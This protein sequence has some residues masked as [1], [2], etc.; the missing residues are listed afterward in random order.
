MTEKKGKGV[1]TDIPVMNLS[2]INVFTVDEDKFPD[3]KFHW[4]NA[5]DPGWGVGMSQG[6]M[7]CREKEAKDV[8]VN[9]YSHPTADGKETDPEAYLKR[10]EMV[11]CWM[12]RDRWDAWQMQQRQVVEQTE[13]A[14]QG[15]NEEAIKRGWKD[16]AEPVTNFK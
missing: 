16:K 7:P 5:T 10:R 1:L 3:R 6:W 8:L 12:A 13:R 2:F 15:L 14:L 4:V 11:L 9:K